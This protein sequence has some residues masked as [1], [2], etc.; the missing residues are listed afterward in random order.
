MAFLT[1]SGPL[2][3]ALAMAGFGW[4]VTIAGWPAVLYATAGVSALGLLLIAAAYRP[5]PAAAA[6]AGDPG[7]RIG[8][9]GLEVASL[10]GLVWGTFNASAVIFLSFAPT[11]LIEQGWSAASANSVASL[12][13][14][15]CLPLI[16]LGGH[17]AD[18]TGR[19]DLVIG[20]TALVSGLLMAA[21]PVAPAPLLILVLVGAVWATPAGPIM[22]M[23]QV[24]PVE[25]RAAGFGVFFTLFY[26]CMATLPP[27]AGALLDRAADATAPLL[28]AATV[29]AS[30]TL[31]LWLFRQRAPGL[32]GQ[33]APSA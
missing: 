24:L 20:G 7:F 5:P 27:A 25:E 31:F 33:A 4:W 9:R 11:F 6:T 12:I 22:A 10:A 15:L 18:R 16:L 8:R 29:M 3:L 28:F 30:T 19:G 21:M 32:E 26:L 17:I 23:P 14:W 1:S 2:G 13:V